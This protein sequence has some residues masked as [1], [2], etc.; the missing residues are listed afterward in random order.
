MSTIFH[1]PGRE[2]YKNVK[3]LQQ[4]LKA[5]AGFTPKPEVGC[6]A[7]EITQ[8]FSNNLRGMYLK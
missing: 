7:L 1:K 4:N 8:S 3:A 2:K 6:Q 5:N